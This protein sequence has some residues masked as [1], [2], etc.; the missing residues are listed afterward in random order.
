MYINVFYRSWSIT[1][2]KVTF[3]D[4]IITIRATFMKPH[5]WI[6]L[7]IRLCF[8]WDSGSGHPTLYPYSLGHLVLHWWHRC[9]NS[10]L[11]IWTNVNVHQSSLLLTLT[12]R[13]W[14]KSLL[15]EN[16]VFSTGVG[17]YSYSQGKPRTSVGL[18]GFLLRI[19]SPF[20]T[21]VGILHD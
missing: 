9:L 15:V 11:L 12:I 17:R 5:R 18:F 6:Y 2:M 8:L 21:Y 19:F 1:P 7:H 16:A 10:Y 14:G 3:L 20:K 13:I 4:Y